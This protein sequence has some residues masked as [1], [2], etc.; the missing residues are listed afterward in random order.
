[1]T[2]PPEPPQS[3]SQQ[4][5]AVVERTKRLV[6]SDNL[7]RQMGPS[8]VHSEMLSVILKDNAVLLEEVARLRQ[9]NA[10]LKVQRRLENVREL[11]AQFPR[12]GR[13]PITKLTG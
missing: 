8:T 2:K 12:K 11:E 13:R 3:L 6:D 10:D 7:L 4:V 5:D 1:M 9:E